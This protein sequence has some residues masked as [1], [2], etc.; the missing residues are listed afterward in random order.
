MHYK[1]VS[2]EYDT[3]RYAIYLDWQ[4]VLFDKSHGSDMNVVPPLRPSRSVVRIE[5]VLRF[6]FSTQLLNKIL[7]G[8]PMRDSVIRN[9]CRSGSGTAMSSWPTHQEMTWSKR[10]KIVR[11]IAQ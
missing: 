9:S 10:S 6:P 3:E 8:L 1:E 2:G 7:R 11:I 5:E 4:V